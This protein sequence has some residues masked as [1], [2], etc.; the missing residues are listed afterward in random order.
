MGCA[1]RGANRIG[2]HCVIGIVVGVFVTLNRPTMTAS[3]TIYAAALI[4]LAVLGTAMAG[5]LVRAIATGE[6]AGA[7]FVVGFTALFAWQVGG[8]IRR[9]RPVV[10]SFEHLPEILLP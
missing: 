3:L 8:F 10:Y 5:L 4:L 7:L 6:F 2:R 1:P 9:N